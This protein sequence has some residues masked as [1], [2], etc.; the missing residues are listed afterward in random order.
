MLNTAT[1]LP[2]NPVRPDA[3]WGLALGRRRQARRPRR[4]PQH[5]RHRHRTDAD[6][7]VLR[8]TANGVLDTTFSADGI[9]T[10]DIEGRGASARAVTVLE[11]DSIVATGY[12]S[13]DLLGRAARRDSSR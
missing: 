12:L 9:V 5:G 6:F 1:P 2:N 4:H 10:L 8:L 7:A 13:S 11:D 3:Q